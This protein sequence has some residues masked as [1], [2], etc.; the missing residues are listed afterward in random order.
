MQN[1]M[2]LTNAMKSLKVS[3]NT[4][5]YTS[6]EQKIPQNLKKSFI[7]A[8]DIIFTNSTEYKGQLGFINEF[9]PGKYQVTIKEYFNKNLINVNVGTK[10]PTPNGL[11]TVESIE[12]EIYKIN[13]VIVTSFDKFVVYKLNDVYILARV[14]SF[15]NTNFIVNNT[16]ISW[17]QQVNSEE[18][19]NSK[20]PINKFSD[21]IIIQIDQITET[22][23][24]GL[25]PNG[26]IFGK[27][28]VSPQIVRLYFLKNVLLTP[29]QIEKIDKTHLKITK[30]PFAGDTILP[31]L[32]MDPHLTITLHSTGKK[33]YNHNVR[34]KNKVINRPIYPKDVFYMDIKLNNRNYAEVVGIDSD[35]NISIKENTNGSFINTT[36]TFN[37]I[38]DY[39]P[40]FKWTDK[41]IEQELPKFNNVNEYDTTLD[42]DDS[43]D[44]NSDTEL[45]ADEINNNYNYTRR[46]N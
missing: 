35:N 15:E 26:F 37:D 29:K 6:Q 4:S 5:Q 32:F 42:A 11:A 44:N 22:F 21:D 3:Q 25:G 40:G 30:G 8:S 20:L 46:I 9:F 38:S 23:Y 36:I 14:I 1:L 41:E 28:H 17:T 33:I 34:Y 43:L 13:N 12:P 7:H 27:L 10:I 39:L 24:Y 16:D 31:F 45:D 2:N 18:Y 19:I